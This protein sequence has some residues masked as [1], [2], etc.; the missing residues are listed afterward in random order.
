MSNS[1]GTTCVGEVMSTVVITVLP[2]DK[3]QTVAAL[4]EKHDIDAAPVV[5]ESNACVGIITSHDLVEYEAV[6]T[7]MIE[8]LDHGLDFDLA[9]YG[10]GQSIPRLR[11]PIDE[12]RIQMTG[13]LETVAPHAPLLDAAH[14]MCEKHVHQLVILNEEKRPIGLLSSLD[15]LGHLAGRSVERRL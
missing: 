8:Y 11:V 15:I 13:Q 10:D 7:R 6:R 5:N 1:I 9:H 2:T 3:L 12:V 14:L 4:F